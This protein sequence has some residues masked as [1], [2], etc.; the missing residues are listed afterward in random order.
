MLERNVEVCEIGFDALRHHEFE[1][2]VGIQDGAARG[3]EAHQRLQRPGAIDEQILE[4][5]QPL[6]QH[7]L[8]WA[9]ISRPESPDA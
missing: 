1:Q 6:R 4:Q 7:N 3:E 8:V 2:R 9:R 5:P